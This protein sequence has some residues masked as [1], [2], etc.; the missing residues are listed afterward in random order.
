[1]KKIVLVMMACCF[2]LMSQAQDFKYCMSY[3]DFVAN[4]WTPID[5]LTQGR[6]LKFPEVKYDYN[7]YKIKTGD[8]VADK[9]LKKN[10][11]AVSAGK[12][13]YV[14]C[15]N[16]RHNDIVLD[17]MGYTQAY[18]YDHDKLCLA[19]Y[20]INDGAFLLGLGADVASLFTS[21]PMSIAL[22][23]TSTALWLASDKLNSFRCYLV[24]HNANEKGRYDVT[25]MNDEY[26]DHLLAHDG[27]LLA[28][29]HA[30]SNKTER[31][32]AANILPTLMAKGLVD[33]E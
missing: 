6:T 22:A 31:Q 16:M 20:H 18:R 29:Y 30:I 17:V 1:M 12:Q 26:M 11:F 7:E 24:D 8:K 9:F 2:A 25:R 32:S 4:K 28:R 15:R 10:V 3:E 14:N 23:T 5:S 21:L 19:V 27:Q 33:K 13:L